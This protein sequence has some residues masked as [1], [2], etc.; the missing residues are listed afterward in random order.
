MILNKEK[1]LDIINER[2]KFKINLRKQYIFKKI[3]E[4]RYNKM[5]N[6]SYIIDLNNI[7][8]NSFMN[9]LKF[10]EEVEITKNCKEL[11]SINDINYQKYG[12]LMIR[13]FTFIQNLNIIESF[14]K[15]KLHENILICMSNNLNL[16]DIVYESLHILINFLYYS[17]N[18]TYDLISNKN[19][20]IYIE[21]INKKERVLEY[22]FKKYF[23][24]L[25]LNCHN[26]NI[27]LEENLELFIKFYIKKLDKSKSLSS[28]D[29]KLIS[30][31]LYFNIEFEEKI[32][33][34][35]I[36]LILN[37]YFIKTKNQN[38]Y[39]QLL[40][41]IMDKFSYIPDS[42]KSNIFYQLINNILEEKNIC[43][44]NQLKL[45]SLTL[46]LRIGNNVEILEPF[47]KIIEYFSQFLNYEEISQENSIFIKE[48]IISF[49]NIFLFLNKQYFHENLNTFE[50]IIVKICNY[51]SKLN[52]NIS[53]EGLYFLENL[54]QISNPQF[55]IYLI[56]LVKLSDLF[57]SLIQKYLDI[58]YYN[59]KELINELLN[60]VSM[61]QLILG[62][63]KEILNSSLEKNGFKDYLFNIKV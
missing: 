38:K 11:L 21:I 31:I 32:I 49:S 10:I 22:E 23:I 45:I 57:S 61:T 3:M 53:L 51:I 33:I 35:L 56:P 20:K 30:I 8:I 50:G 40:I 15:D 25:L 54:F 29:I 39:L 16:N 14:I 58:K 52:Y 19:I 24:N 37:S 12:L 55:I 34:E 60:L 18:I 17:E 48:S 28:K 6:T 26:L 9:S 5:I 13:K 42:N 2:Q 36:N 27:N 62:E 41:N 4:N 7:K 1:K 59:S 43:N 46:S 47:D 63:N 44:F